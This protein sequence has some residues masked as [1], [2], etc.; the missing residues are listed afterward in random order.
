MKKIFLFLISG[1]FLFSCNTSADKTASAKDTTT[2]SSSVALPFTASYSSSFSNDVPDSVLASVLTSYKD[3][4]DGNVA[5]SMDAFGDTIEWYN[6]NGTHIKLPK[7]DMMKIWAGFRDSL[8]SVKYNMRAW[9][10]LYSTDKK[11]SFI[12]TWYFET[13]TYKNG[14]IDSA[15]YHDING[16]K[17]GKIILLETF[18][19][20]MA[21]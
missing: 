17:D 10:K 6:W 14:K 5:K 2:Q 9:N 20:E 13:D 7:A 3:F 21:K 15:A 19:A 1:A 8:S 11:S 12:L 16:L 18:K 4:S